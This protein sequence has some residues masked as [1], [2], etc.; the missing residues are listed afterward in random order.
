MAHKG[1]LESGHRTTA[2]AAAGVLAA[3]VVSL[4]AGPTPVIVDGNPIAASSL[5]TVNG[6]AYVALRPVGDALG[7]QVSFDGRLRQATVTTEFREVV[8][9][10]GKN[11]AFVNGESRRIDAPP[12]LIRGRV[13]MPLRAIAQSLGA[14]VKYDA[15][16]HAIVVSTAGV[17][18][19]PHPGPSPPSV[20]T[21]NTLEGTVTDVNADMVPPAVA[22]DVDHL[23]Y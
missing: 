7:A 10:I 15:G 11:V 19:A 4:G 21:T 18:T 3:A 13:M 2:A 16:I 9:V 1:G 23:S 12:L 8:L 5:A 22:V 6:K 17:N 14:S 20:P